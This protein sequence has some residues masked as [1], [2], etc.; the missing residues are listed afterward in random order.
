MEGEPPGD[1]YLVS[2]E[3]GSRSLEESAEPIR[4]RPAPIGPPCRNAGGCEDPEG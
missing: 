3:K 4:P 1:W 2:G